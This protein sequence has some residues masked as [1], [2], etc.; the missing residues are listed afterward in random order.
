[1]R[2]T[3]IS[4]QRLLIQAPHLP[5][6]EIF[7]GAKDLPPPKAK[8]GVKAHSPIVA[9]GFMQDCLLGAGGLATGKASGF[10]FEGSG[11]PHKVV[12]QGAEQP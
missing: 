8:P 11:E 7:R 10:H 3:E 9:L 2:G 12:E 4:T 6:E 5:S 1:M